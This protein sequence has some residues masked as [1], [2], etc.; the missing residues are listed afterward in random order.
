M[1]WWKFWE[2]K[3]EEPVQ[4]KEPVVLVKDFSK[5][6]YRVY[7]ETVITQ[8]SSDNYHAEVRFMERSG[9][10]VEVHTVDAPTF[11]QTQK[12]VTKLVS[13]KMENFKV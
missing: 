8:P 1:A 4:L 2:T 12:L 3:K 9:V 11:E 10:V 6:Q 13:E 5:S 7:W